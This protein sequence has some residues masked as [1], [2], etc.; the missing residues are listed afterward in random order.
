M[1][2]HV[3]GL[4]M[5]RKKLVSLLLL[6]CAVT[7]LVVFLWL[8]SLGRP[9]LT[10]FV[11]TPDTL[12]YDRIAVHLLETLRLTPSYRT[13]GYPLFLF[14][15]Y[16]L[17]GREY[18]P[19]VTIIIQLFLNL[20]FTWGCWRLLERLAPMA[21]IPLRAAVTLFSFWAGLGMALYLMT[22]FLAALSFG[23]FLYGL[24]F[25]RSSTSVLL[26]GASL[27]LATLTRP[28]FTLIPLLLPF[29]A[30]LTGRATSRVPWYQIVAFTAFSCTATGVSVLYQYRLN[31]YIGPSPMLVQE[32]E[33]TLYLAT[34]QDR[35]ASKDIATYKWEFE[36][37]VEQLARV[38]YARLSPG[39]RERFATQIFR[40]HLRSHGSQIVLLLAKNFLKYLFVPVE[41]LVQRLT[42]YYIGTWLYFRYVRPFLFLVCLPIW[43]LSLIPPIDAARTQRMYY[44]L[45]FTLVMY[46]GVVSIV[47][48][49]GGERIRFPVLG[50]LL[51]LVV[52]NVQ[53]LNRYLHRWTA[54]QLQTEAVSDAG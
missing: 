31:N 52:W 8:W 40:A 32:V 28:T 34:E 38:P 10:E 22:D 44:F 53:K 30:Y 14:V 49:M 24:L 12:G 26:S 7:E 35:V 16:L 48:N 47:A 21:S 18:G 20:G 17:G 3:K 46:V 19:V 11:S 51:P 13:L 42:E 15:G 50:L 33:E 23:V 5:N 36:V 9:T 29:I 43:L 4:T 6:A 37:E 25:W 1:L 45:A 41:S 2:C 27:A 39:E 54:L